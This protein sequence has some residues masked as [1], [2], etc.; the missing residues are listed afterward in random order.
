M[1]ATH[2]ALAISGLFARQREAIAHE[3]TMRSWAERIEQHLATTMRCV[4]CS[5]GG[6]S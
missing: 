5:R 6:V 2:A 4:W 1:R 3:L